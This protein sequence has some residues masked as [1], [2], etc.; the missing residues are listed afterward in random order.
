MTSTEP[1]PRSVAGTRWRKSSRSTS[2]S[3]NCVELGPLP[4]GAAVAVRDSKDRDGGTLVVGA[5]Q[6]VG[7]LGD[8]KR[9]AFD[10]G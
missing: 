8:V 3:A 5:E 1:G 4:D 10:L 7:F 6:W 2:G 9:G